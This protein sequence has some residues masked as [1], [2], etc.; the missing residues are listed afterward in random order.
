MPNQIVEL[1]GD[2]M[3]QPTPQHWI[4]IVL[5]L[6]LPVHWAGAD[7]AA[8]GQRDQQ[9]LAIFKLTLQGDIGGVDAPTRSAAAVELLGMQHPMADNVLAD[10]MGSDR[11]DVLR[12][13]FMA[14]A[15]HHDTRTALVDVAFGRLPNVPAEARESLAILLARAAST[16][17]SIVDRLHTMAGDADADDAQRLASIAVLGECRHTPVR[18]AAALMSLLEQPLVQSQ[19][20]I[21]G[22]TDALARLTGLPQDNHVEVWV[23]WWSANRDRPAERW[24]ADMV[25][26]LSRRVADLEHRQADAAQQQQVLAER[27]LTIHRNLWPLLSAQA[28]ADKLPELLADDLSQLRRFGVARA[29]VLLRDGNA[30]DDTNAAVL[31]RLDDPDASVRLAVAQLLPEL[32]SAN[33][34]TR[35]NARL[36]LER[37]GLVTNAL[38]QYCVDHPDATMDLGTLAHHLSHPSA[39]E[40]AG[41]AMWVRLDYPIAPDVAIKLGEAVAAARLANPETPLSHLAAMLG[42]DEALAAIM[43]LLDSE[44]PEDRTRTAEALR[45][46]GDIDPIKARATDPAVFPVLVR[47]MQSKNGLSDFTAIASLTPIESHMVLWRTALL[48]AAASTPVADRV[49]VDQSLEAIDGI[50]L[51]ERIDLLIPTM[52][53]EHSI[54]QR[55]AT[56]QRLVPLLA[57]TGEDRALIAL[58]SALPKE[59]RP[60]SLNDAAFVAAL[61][62]RQFDSAAT[63]RSDPRPWVTVFE[64]LQLGR[65]ELADMLRT[66]IVRRFHEDLPDTLRAR[67]GMASDPLMGNASDPPGA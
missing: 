47:S 12:A 62:S 30:T 54:D 40:L 48:N 35:V 8:M 33:V 25:Q 11:A 7:D 31:A 22:S 53:P 44:R 60:M 13:I 61:R 36:L 10:S 20:V 6:T 34:P 67:L 9:R 16:T 63:M 3:R 43:P 18:A 46:R 49:Q 37:D 21:T 28:Q 56:A 5:A 2:L 51:Q 45:R 32:P 19:A 42:D 23:A 65:P 1:H 52:A 27:M 41:E 17:P 14:L 64:S 66:E 50:E 26:A 57:A 39:C 58:V 38:L 4:L 59:H 15:D 29:A 55:L 24:L